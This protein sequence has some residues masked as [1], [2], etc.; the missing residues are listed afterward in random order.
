MLGLAQR[1]GILVSGEFAVE[2]AVK[3]CK[4]FL[5]IVAADASDG[6][7]KQFHDMC[8]YYQ[9]E[10]LEC[11][12]KAELGHAIGKDLRSSL[13]VLDEKMAEAVKKLLTD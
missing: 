9:T 7:K 5:V 10:C 11:S 13:A 4:A 1:A 6:T 3:A 8:A 12:T 2:K